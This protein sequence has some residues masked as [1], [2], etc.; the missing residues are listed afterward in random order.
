L[1]HG[2]AAFRE[3]RLDAY[4]A[5]FAQAGYA[6]LVFDYRNWGASDGQPRRVLDI[7]NQ[8]ADWRAAVAYAR[9]L[10]GV[11]TSRVA[12][13]GSSFGGGHVLGLAAHDRALAAAIVQ[14]P[15]VLGPASAFAQSPKLIARL[16]IAAPRSVRRV[17]GPPTPSREGHRPPRRGRDDDLTGRL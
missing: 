5:R 8:H 11:D 15:H 9:T 2:F 7:G 17:A 13:W 6:A 14:V 16:V 1:A 12:G 4:A 10:D 3:L